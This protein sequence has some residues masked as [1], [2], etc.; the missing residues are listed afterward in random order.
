MKKIFAA[1]WKLHKNPKESAQFFLEF[2]SLY[3]KDDHQVVFFVPSTS[4]SAAS[5][6]LVE[7]GIQWGAQN[8][9]SEVK[10]AFTG[11]TSAQVIGELGGQWILLGHSERRSIFAENDELIAKKLQLV[12]S[13]GL[14][15]MICIGE[16]LAERDAGNLQKV[17]ERQLTIGL[18]LADKSK[19]LAVAY[20]PVWA[21]GTGR[22]ASV[23]QVAEA[24]QLVHSLIQKL[25]FTT[26][27]VLYGGSVKAD[28]AKELISTPG[29][30]GFLVGGASLEVKS[31]LA[32][33]DCLK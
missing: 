14:T 33:T 17:L 8:C 2:K 22:V 20:E 5:E 26:L 7:S 18:S 4:A 10:G 6:S 12:Q 28:N 32:I 1:N 9:Y 13:L 16:T 27:P 11:E 3:K 25:G 21:I 31:F 23:L 15:P 29:V 24:H 19:K 30:D